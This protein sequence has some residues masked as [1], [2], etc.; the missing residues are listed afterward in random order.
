MNIEAAMKCEMIWLM[1]GESLKGE[2]E[3]LVSEPARH[4]EF[5]AREETAAAMNG[6]VQ[7]NTLNESLHWKEV[8]LSGIEGGMTR[9]L[10]QFHW[11]QQYFNSTEWNESI[12][13]QIHFRFV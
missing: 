13:H 4:D 10:I 3:W 6:A 7:F 9:A 5:T 1:S 8:K 12:N 11:I 2:N